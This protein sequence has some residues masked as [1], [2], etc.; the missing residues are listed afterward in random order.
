MILIVHAFRGHALKAKN[1]HKNRFKS[2]KKD[3]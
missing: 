2:H 3:F 1:S